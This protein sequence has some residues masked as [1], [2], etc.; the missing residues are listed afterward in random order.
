VPC[1]TTQAAAFLPAFQRRF[2]GGLVAPQAQHQIVKVDLVAV[3]VR[4]V[5]AGELDL[6]AD[7][8]AAAATHAGAVHHHRIQADH[9]LDALRARGVGAAL[10][11]DR[12][13]DGHHLVD[14]GVLGHRLL[15]ARGDQ[16][17]DAGRAIVGADDQ[18]IAAGAELVFPEHQR[19][20][21]KAQHADDVGTA[22]LVGAGLR[23]DRRHAQPAAHADHLLGL[24]D[25]AGDAHR[26]HHRVQPRADRQFCCISRVVLPTAWMTSVIVPLSR[27]KSAMVKGM[28]SP[29]SCSITI[30]NWPGLAAL[31]I[32]GWRISSR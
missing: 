16:A 7:L 29:C 9:G 1:A 22:F 24:P 19:L 21:A 12:R 30:T 15:D 6:F 26:P 10:H 32:S 23:V 18:F 5:D 11:H 2:L 31:A 17:L 8:H 25:V 20:V 4:P 28:R 3:E 14:V 13:A 27:S